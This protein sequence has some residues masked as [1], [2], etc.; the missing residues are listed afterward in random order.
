[1]NIKT[2]RK[3]RKI[4][5]ETLSERTGMQ[6]ATLYNYQ[7]GKRE[8]DIKGL[9]MIAD[10]LGCTVDELIREKEDA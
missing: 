10:A 9:I 4:S 1:M 6:I 5:M 3:D 7:S 8:P 2:I